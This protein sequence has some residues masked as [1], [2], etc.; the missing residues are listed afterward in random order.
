MLS[1]WTWNS[2]AS[3]S[4]V[5]PS[6]S[7]A[8]PTLSEAELHR[9]QQPSTGLGPHTLRERIRSTAAQIPVLAAAERLAQR[10]VALGAGVRSKGAPRPSQK[11]LTSLSLGGRRSLTL[12]EMD[13][14]R[15]LVG[16]GAESVTTI[17]PVSAG[18]SGLDAACREPR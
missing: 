10:M 8:A 4:D 15:Y 18:A 12:V 7:Q 2:Q 16:C 9:E 17:L 3:V 11:I 6:L 5:S 13:G 1:A 14:Q